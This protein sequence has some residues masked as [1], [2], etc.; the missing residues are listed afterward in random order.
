MDSAGLIVAAGR[1]QR[2]GGEVPKQYLDLDGRAI[3][4]HAIDR[5][6]GQVAIGA[7]A[8][9]VHEDDLPLYQK[10]VKD[11]SDPR[12][13]PPIPGGETR[14][15]SVRSGLEALESL[16]PR[17]VLIHD[18]AR[19]FVSL[20]GIEAVL[21][22]L[23]SRAGAFPALP[24]VDALWSVEDSRVSRSVPREGLWRAQTPQ[25]FHFDAIL[26]A[27]RDHSGEAAD[28]VAVAVAAGLEV[29][30][31][32]GA[33]EN[34]KITTT[35]DLA[36]ARGNSM[37]IPDIRT[38]N[39]YDV[40]QLGPGESVTLCGISIPH[41]QTLIGHSDADVGMHAITDAIFGGL[42]EGDIGYWFPPSDPQW[43]GAASKIF[44]DKAVERVASR[45]F[46]ISHLDCTLICERP[47]IGPHAKAMRAELARITGIDAER[48]SV[49]ATTSEKLG[50]TGRGEG[51][52]ALA[53]ATLVKT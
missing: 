46:V 14:A 24:V 3:L 25:G 1:G 9:V 40:H 39:G 26:A 8:V 16:R 47:R 2:L 28:D 18:G 50:F 49:K 52:A 37:H 21:N 30:V 42:S 19:P 51:I 13:L 23:E 11:L 27:H 38:G 43:R 29:G 5:F 15:A 45:G 12:L 20:Q 31:V 33:E 32:D 34:Y 7:L 36:R 48:V 41:D 35:A 53:T 6:L 17:K 4:R 44:L 10:A 22:A